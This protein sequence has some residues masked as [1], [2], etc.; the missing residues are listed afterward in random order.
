[1]LALTFLAALAGCGSDSTAPNPQNASIAGAWHLQTVNGQALP[2]VI[3]SGATKISIT[4]D[5]VTV[6]DGGTWS[7]T[8]TFSVVVNGGAPQQQ[9]TNDGGT[10]A[11]SGANVVF[12]SPSSGITNA[13]FT[14]STFVVSETNVGTAI[15]SR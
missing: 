4:A 2:F 12:T 5:Q 8:S 7:Q 9:V 3:Q 14:G 11:R 10:W 15:Y 6:T 13:T 1:M